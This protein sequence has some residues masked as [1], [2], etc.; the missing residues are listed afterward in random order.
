M[1]QRCLPVKN[2]HSLQ[3][4][5]NCKRFG[6]AVVGGRVTARP[7]GENMKQY[8]VIVSLVLIAFIY[9]C[10]VLSSE[11][12]TDIQKTYLP[13][14]KG[15]SQKYKIKYLGRGLEDTL[16]QFR[17]ETKWEILEDLETSD[18]AIVMV[19]GNGYY[20]SPHPNL[21]DTTSLWSDTCYFKIYETIDTLYLGLQWIIPNWDDFWSF[22]PIPKYK[23]IDKNIIVI[24]GAETPSYYW[25]INEADILINRV[26]GLRLVLEKGV[27]IKKI[28]RRG[29][30][31]YEKYMIKNF[32]DDI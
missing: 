1:R 8:E 28:E 26:R 15:S 30:K 16:Y 27:G 11:D 10:G 29:Y 7:L 5:I 14:V 9:G 31:I 25:D 12:S 21:P 3:N 23:K 4:I 20:G 19:Y 17:G 13:L 2:K 32:L 6:F 18:T 24:M 22:Y